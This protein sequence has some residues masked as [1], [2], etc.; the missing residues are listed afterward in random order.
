MGTL[1]EYIDPTGNL[2]Q[3]QLNQKNISNI[4]DELNRTGDQLDS[5]SNNLS[6]LAYGSLSYVW[7]GTGSAD[8]SV[9]PI[10]DAS[11]TVSTAFVVLIFMQ[12]SDIPN[13]VYQLPYYDGITNPNGDP[14]ISKTLF[15]GADLSRQQIYVNQTFYANGAPATF[16]YNYYVIQQPTTNLKTS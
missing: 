6:I 4:I 3:D 9:N 10:I 5:L 11:I 7:N 16:T 14:V 12:R 8:S 1:Q 13:Q 15:G 2:G